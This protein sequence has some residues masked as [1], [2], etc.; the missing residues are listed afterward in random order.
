MR[1][2]LTKPVDV[3]DDNGELRFTHKK[4]SV[5]DWGIAEAAKYIEAKLARP[6]GD[7]A[8]EHWKDWKNMTDEQRAKFTLPS[9]HVAINDDGRAVESVG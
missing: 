8:K 1:I 4:G 7:E 3:L 5:H 6:D 9:K 2:K